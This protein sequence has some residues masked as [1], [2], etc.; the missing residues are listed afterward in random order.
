MINFKEFMGMTKQGKCPPGFRYDKELKVCVPKG[1]GR[2][3]GAFGFGV[4]RPQANTDVENGE[5]DN[6]N[7]DTGKLTGNGKGNGN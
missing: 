4:A 6:G 1:Q 7:M 3:Y 2:Y 5:T